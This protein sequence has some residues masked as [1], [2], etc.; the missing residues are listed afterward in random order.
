MM[1]L[2][3][4]RPEGYRVQKGGPKEDRK[5]PFLARSS[6]PENRPKKAFFWTLRRKVQGEWGGSAH[7]PDPTAQSARARP[8]AAATHAAA[9]ARGAGGAGEGGGGSLGWTRV[10]LRHGGVGQGHVPGGSGAPLSRPQGPPSIRSSGRSL[11]LNSVGQKSADQL[12]RYGNDD[13]PRSLS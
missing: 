4:L 5:V 13:A 6:G 1:S 9:R 11:P 3:G 10:G 8:A 12:R 2:S 7:S